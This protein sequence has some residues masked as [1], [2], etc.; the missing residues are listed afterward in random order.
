[1]ADAKKCDR[2]GV[3][4][5]DNSNHKSWTRNIVGIFLSYQDTHLD[6]YDLCDDCVEKL[7]EFLS[8]PDKK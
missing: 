5:E 3:F 4:Y 8:N 7:K 1:M 2:C 6:R